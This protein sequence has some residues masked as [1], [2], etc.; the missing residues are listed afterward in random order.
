MPQQ[1]GSRCDEICSPYF[2]DVL[3]YSQSFTQHL[4]HVRT[5]L[6]RLRQ[7]GVKLKARKCN[8]FKKEINYLGH[9]VA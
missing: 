8:L 3:V 4:Q 2:D 6:R 1:V 9:I 7:Y 5:V